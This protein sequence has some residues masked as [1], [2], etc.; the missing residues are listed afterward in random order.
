MRRVVLA[1]AFGACALGRADAKTYVAVPDVS[2]DDL[3]PYVRA[4]IVP[5]LHGNRFD[6][7]VCP[8]HTLH[9]APTPFD[10]R[11]GDFTLVLID[12]VLMHDRHW[13]ASVTALADSFRERVPSLTPEERGNMRDLVWEELTRSSEILPRIQSE[14]LEA[15]KRSRLRCGVCEEDPAYAPA[16]RR[17]H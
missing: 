1:V 6:L 17:I 4:N 9:S 10:D 5:E 13:S 15:R 11:L 7:W 2:W 3:L 12:E 14:F 16:A 8:A